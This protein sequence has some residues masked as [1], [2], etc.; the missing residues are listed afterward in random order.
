MPLV[1]IELEP[2]G[3][4][5]WRDAL[6]RRCAAVLGDSQCQLSQ[7]PELVEA[8]PQG[9]PVEPPLATAAPPW[10]ARVEWGDESFSVVTV[11]LANSA[12]ARELSS[13]VS[14]APTDRVFERWSSVGLL[15]AAMVTAHPAPEGPA[16]PAPPEPKPVPPKPKPKPKPYRSKPKPVP[17]LAP[18]LD[19]VGVAASGLSAGPPLLGAEVRLSVVFPTRMFL[20]GAGGFARASQDVSLAQVRSQFGLGYSWALGRSIYL[21]PHLVLRLGRLQFSAEDELRRD[22][23]TEWQ[24]GSAAGVDLNWRI[25][26]YWDLVLGVELA[27]AAPFRVEILDE[28]SGKLHLLRPGLLAGLRFRTVR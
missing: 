13:S 18:R 10:R 14:F 19:L 15:I 21:E 2:A 27:A 25:G 3:E 1:L 7:P 23:Q 16:E 4:Q 6:L 9:A 28:L 12:L 20:I 17:S 5:E 8:S 11:R 24:L 22:T 26:T